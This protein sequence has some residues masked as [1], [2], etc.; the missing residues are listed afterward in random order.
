MSKEHLK[1]ELK[2]SVTKAF[3][4]KSKITKIFHSLSYS[5]LL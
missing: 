4:K 3:F 2:F 5:V 1:V